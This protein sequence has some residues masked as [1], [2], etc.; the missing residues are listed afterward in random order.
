MAKLAGIPR[1]VLERAREI[2]FNLEK[3][4][5]DSEGIPKIS[6]RQNDDTDDSQL[7][8][9]GGDEKYRLLKKLKDEIDRCDVSAMTPVEALNMIDRLKKEIK[10][11]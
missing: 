4:E 2:L 10:E 6:Y 1:T 3:K 5:L 8:L 9:F 7:F 11:G